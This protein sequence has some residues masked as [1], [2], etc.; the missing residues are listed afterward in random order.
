MI[1]AKS[2]GKEEDTQRER[3]RTADCSR[4]YAARDEVFAER[5][6]VLQAERAA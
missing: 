4:K 5:K 1:K 3:S 6:N 2:R